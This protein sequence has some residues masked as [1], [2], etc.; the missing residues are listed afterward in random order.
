MV[1]KYLELGVEKDKIFVTVNPS[2]C[3]WSLSRKCLVGGKLDG[4]PSE[5]LVAIGNGDFELTYENNRMVSL[6]NHSEIDVDLINNSTGIIIPDQPEEYFR[7]GFVP[8][9]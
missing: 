6:L 4:P 9:E 1:E 3:T 5:E 2:I 8:T 7:F